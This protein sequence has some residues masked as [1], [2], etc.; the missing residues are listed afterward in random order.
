MLPCR[1]VPWQAGV[2]EELRELWNDADAYLRNRWNV[3]DV[4]GLVLSGSGFA[5]RSI[6][7]EEPWG[8]ALYALAAPFLFS[9][10]LF[11][12]QILHFQGPMIQ[13]CDRYRPE[14]HYVE[15][16]FMEFRKRFVWH[17]KPAV[18]EVPGINRKQY[19]LQRKK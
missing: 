11:F 16:N 10:I 5:V 14:P 9:R 8:R 6:D 13:V 12:G 2:F 3:L 4:L 18:T 17:R 1:N 7:N 19:G 15:R